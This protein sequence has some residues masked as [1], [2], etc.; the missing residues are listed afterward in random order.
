MPLKQAIRHQHGDAAIQ[1]I[2]R[3]NNLEKKYLKCSN[4]LTFLMKCRDQGIIPKGLRLRSPV[5]SQSA[6]KILQQASRLLVKERIRHHRKTKAHSLAAIVDQQDK[7]QSILQPEEYAQL[8]QAQ[9]ES[10]RQLNSK[11]K[12][13]QQQKFNNLRQSTREPA[14][15]HQSEPVRTQYINKTVVNLSTKALTPHQLSLLAKGL[16]FVPTTKTIPK[17]DFIVDIEEGLQQLAPG[18]HIDYLRHQVASLLDKAQPQR[19]N[20]TKEESRALVKLKKDKSITIA[21]ADKGKAAA[22]LDK[23]DFNKLVDNLLT[24][25]STYRTLKT[26]PTNKFDRQHRFLLNQLK[27]SGEITPEIQ[28]KLTVQHPVHRMPVQPSKS[29]RNL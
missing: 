29:T 18:G 4:H 16:N 24:D 19:T 9:T 3:L 22:I 7:I 10:N 21:P 1:D 12:S 25:Q 28:R 27:T 13:S 15:R 11:I 20:L 8:R 23:T 26:D 5:H 14:H 6:H 2:N 17:D